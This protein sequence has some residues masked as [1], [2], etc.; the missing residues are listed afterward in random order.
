M[1][2]LGVDKDAINI[3]MDA[4]A[5]PLARLYNFAKHFTANLPALISLIRLFQA[6]TRYFILAFEQKGEEQA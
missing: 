6:V 5:N 3:C 2:I 1:R 4:S